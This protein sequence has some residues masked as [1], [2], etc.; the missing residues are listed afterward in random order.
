MRAALYALLAMSVPVRAHTDSDNND[1]GA[2]IAV[3]IVIVVVFGAIYYCMYCEDRERD[4]IKQLNQRQQDLLR[5]L[6]ES[7][8]LEKERR[9]LDEER[10]K[11]EKE[12]AKSAAFPLKV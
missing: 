8:K 10:R 7:R 6:Q 11:F 12:A 1:V 2:I 3:F 4:R 5:S 9:E